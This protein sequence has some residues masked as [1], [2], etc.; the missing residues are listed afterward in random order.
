MTT[1]TQIAQTKIQNARAAFIDAVWANEGPDRL[2]ELAS[3]AGMELAA[4][5]AFIAR[6]AEA[7]RDIKTASEVLRLR[8]VASKAKAHSDAIRARADAAIE[9]LESEADLAAQDA[10]S[11]MREVSS[12]ESAAW[13]V[14]AL[15]DDGMLPA[16]QLPR[17]LL[18]LIERRE[19]EATATR[20][21]ATMVAA[22]TER[23][24]VRDD[25][26][27]LERH[28]WKL[29]LSVDRRERETLLKEEL[30][31]AKA[32]LAAAESRLSDAERA[33]A[34]ARKGL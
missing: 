22:I 24:R 23:N 30:D 31:R 11:A 29:P 7:R 21:H 16:S 15:H 28:L 1:L 9:K 20:S 8:R 12:A 2:A 33:H 34:A 26:E 14:I 27:R 13:R 25:V 4:A 17:D 6:V 19:Q 18:A 10:T 32:N 5:D 3:D